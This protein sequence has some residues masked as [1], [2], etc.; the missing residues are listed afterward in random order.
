[1]LKYLMITKRGGWWAG[2]IKCSILVAGT[3]YCLPIRTPPSGGRSGFG[4]VAQLAL[5]MKTA[6]QEVIFAQGLVGRVE[7]SMK[8]LP[9][10]R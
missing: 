7:A 6:R 3:A 10:W 9:K 5:L 1:M 4:A 2:C 8:L